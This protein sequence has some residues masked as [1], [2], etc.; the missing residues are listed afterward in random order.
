MSTDTTQK[1]AD[2]PQELDPRERWRGIA[3][4]KVTEAELDQRSSGFLKA[5]SRRLLGSLLKPYL[6]LVWVMGAAVIAENLARLASPWLV[7]RGIDHGIP[8]LVQDDRATELI[9]TV[10]LMLVALAVQSITRI[11]FLRTSGR[12]G[13]EALLDLRRRVFQHF[14]KLDVAFHDRYTSGRVVSRMT[15]DM[16]AIAELLAGGFDGLLTAILTLVGTSVMLLVLD[17]ELGLMSL[18]SMIF[19][20]LLLRWFST[21]SSRTFRTIR[22]RSAQVIVHFVETMTGIKAV[23]SY[24]REQRNQELF[25]QLADDYGRANIRSFR[26][27][28][29]FMPGIKLVG[30]VTIGLVLLWGGWRVMHGTMTLGVLTAFLLYLRNFYEPM[31]DIGQFYNTFQSASSALEKLSGVLDEESS[32]A[33]PADPTPLPEPKGKV[34]FDHVRF[35]YVDGRPVL[36]DLDLH[37]P[38]GQTVALVGTTGAGKTTIAKL[39]ARFYDPTSGAVR[40][41]DVDERWLSDDDLRRAVI[42]VTQENF[43]FNGT[44]AENIEFGRPGATREQVEAAARAVGAHHFIEALPQGYDTPVAKRGERLS[45]GQRQLVAFSRA[46]LADPAVLILDEATSSLDIP[47]ERLVQ[48]ALK[49]L[50]ASR[51]AVIIAHRLS[52]VE[53]ADRVLVLEHGKVLEDGSPADLMGQAGGRYA[54]LHDAWIASLA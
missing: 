36:P 47:S 10:V 12:V 5:R 26:L 39:I 46:F 48:H 2:Q 19:V 31:Q 21:Q 9:S 50:L 54:S 16:D 8:A 23:Q 11:W 27:F 28:A 30:N 51:T 18:A 44:I 33:A 6:G 22:E 14:Q 49:T 53:I 32:V 4:E 43:M 35:E 3:A 52:T 29:I 13:Q 15:S 41:D 7:R 24:R 34:D 25:A 45:A 42:L 38:A 20:G 17:L 1:R 40:L 37:I